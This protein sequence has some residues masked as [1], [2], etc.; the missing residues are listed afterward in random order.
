VKAEGGTA[1]GGKTV[2]MI[3]RHLG[4]NATRRKLAG[5]IIG[6]TAAVLAGRTLVSAAKGGSSKAKGKSKTPICHY[7]DET[8][9][10]TFVQVPV[11]AGKGHAK[12]TEDVFVDSDGAAVTREYCA[13]LNLEPEPEL[14]G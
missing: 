3:S 10:Y 11:K 1:V 2:Q 6:A 4:T 13:S 5:G 7:D 12:H 14:L 9:L 8:G